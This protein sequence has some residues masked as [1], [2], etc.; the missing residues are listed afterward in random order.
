MKLLRNTENRKTKDKNSENVPHLEINKAMLVHCNIVNNDYQQNSRVLYTFIPSKSFSQ[1]FEISPPS[2]MFLMTFN[3]EFSYIE[4]WF[5]CQNSKLLEI[6]DTINFQANIYLPSD[7]LK[8]SSSHILKTSLSSLQRNNFSSSRTSSRHLQDVFK[9]S[10]KRR[11]YL[12]QDVFKTYSTLVFKMSSTHVL[13]TSLRH[14]GDQN[15]VYLERIY[16][17]T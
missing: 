11:I 12:A 14:L 7:A 8:T 9:A 10:W 6:E 5:T 17:C 2:F 1:L 13:K 3:S 15:N 4:V 16:I